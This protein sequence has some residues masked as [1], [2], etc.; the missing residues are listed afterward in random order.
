MNSRESATGCGGGTRP[1][2]DVISAQQQLLTSE[3][4]EV[5]VRGQRAALV[6]YL[7][8]A[9]GG[10]WHDGDDGSSS[11]SIDSSVLLPYPIACPRAPVRGEA[12]TPS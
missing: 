8:K 5:Q 6:V 11:T 3:R 2:I 4:Q 1:H 12:A 7:A 9:L 10:G